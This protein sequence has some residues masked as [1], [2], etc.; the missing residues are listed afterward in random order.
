MVGVVKK[1]KKKRI[2]RYVPSAEARC[3]QSADHGWWK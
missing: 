3:M 2:V 1:K